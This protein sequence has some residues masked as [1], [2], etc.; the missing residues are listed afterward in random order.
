MD[1]EGGARFG[2]VWLLVLAALA[3]LALVLTPRL[4]VPYPQ[5]GAW[6]ESPAVFPAL[7][8]VL[9]VSGALAEAWRRRRGAA[10]AGGEEID[11]SEADIPRGARVVVLFAIYAVAVP[12]LGLGVASAL[13]LLVT[14]RAVG[15]GW[16]TS[17]LLALPLAAV[18]WGVFVGLL[19][20]SFGRGFLF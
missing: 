12:W 11:P 10:P 15:L 14:G 5:Q 20:L 3:L 19:K 16:R 1:S 8:L 17:A 18:L 2:R 6:Y 9:M 13:F 4:I 7:G